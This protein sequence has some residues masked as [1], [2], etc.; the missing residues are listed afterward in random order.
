[1]KICKVEGCGKKHY[2]LDFCSQHYQKFKRYGDPLAGTTAKLHGMT[3]T[4]E[5]ETWRNMKKRCYNP[6]SY[7]YHNYGGRGIIVCDRWIH[8]FS[9][10]Y[11]DM[12]NKP[13]PKAQIDREV[14]DGNY[15]PDNCKWVTNEENSHNKRNNA[16]NWFT[17][18]SIRRL[19]RM[20]RYTLKE[21]S[22]IYNIN[23]NTLQGIIYNRTWA[24]AV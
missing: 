8:S 17:V 21:L 20:K 13:F 10:F 2:A 24:E 23:I 16:V 5:Y 15:E 9:N 19:F 18:R 22:M 14:N 4:A 3:G 12:G 11:N 7:D 1:M 6:N